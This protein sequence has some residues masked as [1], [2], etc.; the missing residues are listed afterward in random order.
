MTSLRRER[1]SQWQREKHVSLF[2]HY[3]EEWD[4]FNDGLIP[5]VEEGDYVSTEEYMY[6]YRRVSKLRIAPFQ[7]TH[8]TKIVPR[9]WYP[10]QDMAD[11]LDCGMRT[12]HAMH[13]HDP[14]PPRMVL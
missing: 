9:D 6:W 3:I 5:V 14:P 2:N 8:P 13:L 7:T 11:A 12:L 10:Q 1:L 4:A